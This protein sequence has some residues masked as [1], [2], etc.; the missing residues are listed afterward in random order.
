MT[1]ETGL[2]RPVGRLCLALAALLWLTACER[3]EEHRPGLADERPISTGDVVLAP[4][5]PEIGKPAE[6]PMDP[7]LSQHV[8]T[9]LRANTSMAELTQHVEV[10]ALNDGTVVLRGMVN[11]RRERELI[12]EG[13]KAIPKV[14]RVDNQIEV[15]D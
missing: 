1:P 15:I 7:A 5:P 9:A 8:R 10:T 4:Q 12:E 3:P 14:Q 13:I 11:S 6:A 2:I